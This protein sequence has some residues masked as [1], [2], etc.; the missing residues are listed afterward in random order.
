MLDWFAADI[1]ILISRYSISFLEGHLHVHNG[2]LIQVLRLRS[3]A[4]T[5][6]KKSKRQCFC[7]KRDYKT[8]RLLFVSSSSRKNLAKG[9][10]T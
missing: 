3:G 4:R 8:T 6:S 1:S 10:F 9:G 2:Y 7:K 5:V